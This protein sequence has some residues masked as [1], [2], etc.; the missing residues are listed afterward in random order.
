MTIDQNDQANFVDV[1]A[2]MYSN[3]NLDDTRD[4]LDYGSVVRIEG[5]RLTTV[6]GNKLSSSACALEMW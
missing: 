6:H 4:N 5:S 1:V 2:K 3:P